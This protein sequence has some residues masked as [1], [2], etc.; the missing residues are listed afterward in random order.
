MPLIHIDVC[1]CISFSMFLV[2]TEIFQSRE[3]NRKDKNAVKE[4][5]MYYSIESGMQDF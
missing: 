5:N 2:C 1:I 4:A 3:I